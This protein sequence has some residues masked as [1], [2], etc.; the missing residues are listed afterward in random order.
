MI[1]VSVIIPCYNSGSTL[2][3]A[4]ESIQD[5]TIKN[6][7]II[8]VNDGSDDSHTLEVLRNIPKK[9]KVITQKN[10]GLSAAR[11]TGIREAK[12]KYILPLDSDDYLLSSFVEVTLK[13][14]KN[15]NNVFCIFTD[16]NMFGEKEGI[17]ERNYNYFVQLF[18]NQLPYCLL[19]EK[20]IWSEIGGYD[21]NMKIGYEDWEFN[22]RLGKYGYY[23]ERINQAL[24]NYHISNT[25]ML[26]S[27]SDKNYISILRDIRNK[28]KD[29]YCI[30]ELY[31]I[32]KKWRHTPMP[33]PTL[34]YIGMYLA[35][36][37]L[38]GNVY[39]YIYSTLR[40][41]KQS[42]RFSR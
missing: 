17:L 42:E 16:I 35:T 31:R 22:I 8:V 32:W 27:K 7:E 20:K 38:P 12:G 25:G 36:E 10:M 3:R 23:P 34:L 1:E 9:I 13:K 29:I 6:I 14:I 39:N 24:F 40:F 2:L 37:F 33:Y 30:S 11:N 15:E 4:V 19:Y 41:L 21:E 28:H 18:T 26:V 5:Q